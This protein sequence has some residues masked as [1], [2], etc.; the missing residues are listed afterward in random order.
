M[1]RLAAIVVWLLSLGGVHAANSYYYVNLYW[2]TV[3][4]D[5]R[6]WDENLDFSIHVY[7]KLGNQTIATDTRSAK[8]KIR[9]ATA[10][11]RHVIKIEQG[12]SWAIYI[13]GRSIVRNGW[14]ISWPSYQRTGLDPD[15]NWVQLRIVLT[16]RRQE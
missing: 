5:W 1:I 8:P 2:P 9:E 3:E 14:V 6:A 7:E 13:P 16:V 11:T 15:T 10:G 4:I 12:D